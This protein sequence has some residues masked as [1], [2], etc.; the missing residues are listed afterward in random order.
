MKRVSYA[1]PT[2]LLA[3]LLWLALA[4]AATAFVLPDAHVLSGDTYPVTGE[5]LIEGTEVGMVETE[6]GEK[7]TGNGVAISGE[8]L[9]LSASGPGT[10]TYKGVSEPKSKTSCNTAGQAPGTVRISGEYDM[11]DISTTPLTIAGLLLFKE[12]AVECNSGKLKIKARGPILV[13]IEKVTSEAD[14]T[15]FGA[16]ENCTAKGKQELKEYLNDEGVKVKAVLTLNFGLGFETGCK[17]FT[18]EI[19]VRMNK[20]VAVVF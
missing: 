2:A 15:E 1:A 3:G 6:L 11:V 4:S 19:V 18:K 9:E 13:K 8:F 12:V 16:V 7:L 5:G 10:L 17:R 20:M 14:L